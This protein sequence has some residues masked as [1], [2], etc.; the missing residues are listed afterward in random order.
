[1]CNMRQFGVLIISAC[2]FA[3]ILSSQQILYTHTS[4]VPSPDYGKIVLGP[5]DFT[6]DGIP[7]YCVSNPNFFGSAQGRIYCYSGATFQLFAVIDRP[8]G[9]AGFGVAIGPGGDRNG[10]GRRDLLVTSGQAT[11]IYDVATQSIIAVMP[12][13]IAGGPGSRSALIGDVDG[14]GFEDFAFGG[15]FSSPYLGAVQVRR[16]N[17]TL[18]YTIPGTQPGYYFGS[19]IAALGDIDGDGAGDFAV[20]APNDI[21]ALPFFN[22]NVYVH[23]GATGSLITTIVGTGPASR[24]GAGLTTTGDVDGDGKKDLVVFAPGG[25]SSGIPNAN[26]IYGQA[27]VISTQTFQTLAV[28]DCESN[29]TCFTS[30]NP[31]SIVTRDPLFNFASDIDGDGYPEFGICRLQGSYTGF[32]LISTRTGEIIFQPPPPFPIG[33][34]AYFGNEASEIG[35]LNGDGVSELILAGYLTPFSAAPGKA[36]VVSAQ[37]AGVEF[38]GTSLPSAAGPGPRIGA[39]GS[40]ALGDELTLNISGIDPY[41]EAVLFGSLSSTMFGGAA[42]PIDFSSSGI[43]NYPLLVAPDVLVPL[44]TIPGVGSSGWASTTV[45]IP[46][47]GSL[48]GSTFFGQWFAVQPS[49]GSV[50]V[51]SRGMRF[52]FL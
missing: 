46:T 28:Y 4:P 6:G 37:A 3:E 39:L 32:E 9:D 40:T 24:F 31:W 50:G 1:M 42:L 29:A 18:I 47:V 41:V 14:D 11:R 51:L 49:G 26:G 25:P 45:S 35:D 36:Y 10:D 22:S 38:F 30:V 33:S 2:L 48:Q 15:S 19:T 34:P 23:S 43:L 8:I 7:D 27:S 16:N 13:Y 17:G 52:T 44:G 21:Q 20:G 5:G 12:P